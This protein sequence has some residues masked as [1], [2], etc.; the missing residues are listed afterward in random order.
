MFTHAALVEFFQFLFK[1]GIL[2][3]MIIPRLCTL[4]VSLSLGQG[5][6]LQCIQEAHGFHMPCC[7]VPAAD[8]QMVE[9]HQED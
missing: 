6:Y 2:M 3:T 4:V 7:I 5:S 1:H 8:I 9:V